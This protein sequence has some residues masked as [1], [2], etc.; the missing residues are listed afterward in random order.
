VTGTGGDDTLSGAGGEVRMAGGRG[1]DTYL[2]DSAGDVVVEYANEGV[3]TVYSGLS[4]ALGAYSENLVLTGGR[5]INGT[6][7][8]W[9][10]MLTG[11]DAA[12]ILKGLAGNDT[13]AGGGGNDLVVGGSGQDA[14]SGGAGADGFRYLAPSDGIVFVT[15]GVRGSWTGDR[16]ADFTPGADK[17][18]LAAAAF[19]LA[20]GPAVEGVNFVAIGTAYNGANAH[21]AAYDA[22][23]PTLVLDAGHSLYYD[24]N[25]KAAGYTLL[26]TFGNGA[27]IH[28][29]DIIIA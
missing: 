7:S 9:H 25:G 6:G 8:A 24:A 27:N 15:N 11:N 20:K 29:S 26:A 4:F 5:A 19:A 2:V 13:I 21:A 23:R 14:L 18:S 3:D 12:N 16:I 17:I 10:N 28:A 1:N 22:G